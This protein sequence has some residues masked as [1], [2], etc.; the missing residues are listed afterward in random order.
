MKTIIEN[1]IELY[2]VRPGVY[3]SDPK[4]N[5]TYR[6][7]FPGEIIKARRQ[8]LK[9]TQQELADRIGVNIGTISRYESGNIETIAY[10][11]RQQIASALDCTIDYLD[12][13]TD[14]PHETLQF[15]KHDAQSER[16]L[17]YFNRLAPDQKAAV[18]AIMKSMVQEE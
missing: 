8:D 5:I 3:E 10:E 15:P 7:V 18:E 4:G 17:A 16:I 11:R 13:Y 1:G 6:K 12:A 9:M 2:E 14:N